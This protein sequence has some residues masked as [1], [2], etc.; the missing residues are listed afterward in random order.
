MGTTSAPRRAARRGT[1]GRSPSRRWCRATERRCACRRCRPPTGSAAAPGARTPGTIPL[2][3]RRRAVRRWP[4]VPSRTILALPS[5]AVRSWARP[6]PS[7]AAIQPRNPIPVVPITEVSGRD[8][9]SASVLARSSSC[10]VAAPSV[11]AAALVTSAPRR[12]SRA[13]SSASRRGHRHPE[14]GERRPVKVQSCHLCTF[15]RCFG[16]VTPRLRAGVA[17]GRAAVAAGNIDLSYER[18]CGGRCCR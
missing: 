4:S 14:R 3:D 2:A 17:A 16:A 6:Q 8:A 7:A 11:M 12:V 9:I 1:R 18:C 15:G 5:A 10:R 13:A